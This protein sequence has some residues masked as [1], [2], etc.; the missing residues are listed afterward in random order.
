MKRFMELPACA[1]RARDVRGSELELATWNGVTFIP[2]FTM[3]CT[4]HACVTKTSVPVNHLGVHAGDGEDADMYPVQCT[5][6]RVR[7]QQ[8]KDWKDSL[9]R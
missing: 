5:G 6:F 8:W 1:L 3:G 7:D 4:G 2:A 9:T